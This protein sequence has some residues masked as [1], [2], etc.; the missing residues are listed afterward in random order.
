VTGLVGPTPVPQAA[1]P[2]PLTWLYFPRL[3]YLRARNFDRLGKHEQAL[4]NYRLFLKLAGKDAEIWG[5]EE[6]ARRAVGAGK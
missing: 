4:E 5:D 1:G 2:G 3:F 6:R